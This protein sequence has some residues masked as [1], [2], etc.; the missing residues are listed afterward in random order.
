MEKLPHRLLI[1][2]AGPVGCEMAQAF[3]RLGS[4]VTLLTS[5]DRVLPRDDSAASCVLGEVFA[6][7]G[8]DV[9]YNARARRAWQAE[10]GIHLVANDR[11]VEGDALLIASGRRPN[12]YGLDLEKAGVAYS[13]DGIQV[14]DHLETSARHIYA[15]GDCT[16]GPQFT[17]YAGWQAFLAVRNALLPGASRGIAEHVPWTTF[18]DPEVA[19]VGL[20]ESQAK[21]KFGQQCETSEWPMARVDR[22]RTEGSTAGFIKLVYKKNGTL[23]GATVVAERAGEVI[24]EWIV[25]LEHGPKVYDL[26]GIIHIYPTYS[27]AS[28]QV[29]AD[30]RLPWV[31]RGVLGKIV[32]ALA[33]LKR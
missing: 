8:I 11:E 18:T 33:K 20:T 1:V 6:A 10:D 23:L 21:E 22:A 16:G 5:R 13:A 9:R 4:R 29:S 15:A 31:L 28:M 14:N 19:H 27:T 32:L 2:G 17:H 3:Q 25:A 12:V 7:E 26:S 30:I 24:H